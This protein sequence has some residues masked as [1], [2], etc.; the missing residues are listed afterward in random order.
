MSSTGAQK[1]AWSVDD[2]EG[3]DEKFTAAWEDDDDDDDAVN[4]VNHPRSQDTSDDHNNADA[5][6][7]TAS[8]FPASA[9]PTPTT[10]RPP[11]SHARAS[12]GGAATM[13]TPRVLLNAMNNKGNNTPGTVSTF[14]TPLPDA[15]EGDFEEMMRERNRVSNVVYTRSFSL[16]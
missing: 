12:F 8:T 5:A 11:L 4:N 10:R 7:G 2:F 13:T 3:E 15:G 16:F 6:T 1:L 9:A 14:G